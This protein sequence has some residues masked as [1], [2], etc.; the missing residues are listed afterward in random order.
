MKFLPI[1]INEFE[2]KGKPKLETRKELSYAAMLQG[3]SL[4]NASTCLPHRLQYALST[5]SDASHA[6]GLAA[7]YKVWLNMARPEIAGCNYMQIIEFM[8]RIGINVTLSDL[9][10]KKENIAGIINRVEG[11]LDLDPSFKN[12]DQLIEILERSL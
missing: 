2:T 6:C 3:F 9:G 11:A 5:V 8:E 7:I 10:I 12:S 4:A 1:A